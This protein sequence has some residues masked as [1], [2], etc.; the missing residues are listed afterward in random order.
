MVSEPK[1]CKAK[2]TPNIFYWYQRLKIE[3]K[4]NSQK[5]SFLQL[6]CMDGD[7]N[8]AYFKQRIVQVNSE[9]ENR[10]NINHRKI[11]VFKSNG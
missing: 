5:N 3:E 1:N 11:Q 8:N 9:H 10:T 7:N 2:D 4:W 6:I